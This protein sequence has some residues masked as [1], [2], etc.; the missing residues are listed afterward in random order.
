MGGAAL[1]VFEAQFYGSA[2]TG[3][4]SKGLD[5]VIEASQLVLVCDSSILVSMQTSGK[6]GLRLSKVQMRTVLMQ[7]HDQGIG[8][9]STI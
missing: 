9:Q 7:E 8:S 2:P 6:R 5:A 1:N 3:S 4:S